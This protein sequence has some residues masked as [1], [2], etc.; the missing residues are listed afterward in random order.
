MTR[1][2]IWWVDFGLAFGSM[3]LGRR[4][5]VIV[6]HLMER[7]IAAV[8]RNP[9]AFQFARLHFF[10]IIVE[11]KECAAFQIPLFLFA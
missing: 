11:F 8:R 10:A 7:M 9:L 4:P 1:G 6:E 5:A 3:T 2:D